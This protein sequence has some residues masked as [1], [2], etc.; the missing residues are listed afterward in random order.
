MRVA[1]DFDMVIFDKQKGI[2][3]KEAIT[4]INACKEQGDEIT[5]FTSRSDDQYS[6]VKALLSECNYDRLICGKPQYD[7]FIDDKAVKFNGW[8]KEYL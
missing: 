5:I 7:I 4:F 3:H 1:I 2:L 6:T 8:D